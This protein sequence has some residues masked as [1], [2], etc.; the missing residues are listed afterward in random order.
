M[1]TICWID[2][3]ATY[4]GYRGQEWVFSS[5]GSEPIQSADLEDIAEHQKHGSGLCW[6]ESA[7]RVLLN[8]GTVK[9]F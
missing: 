4:C 6:I 5:F 9:R 3:N 8:N 1:K 7:A 2:T